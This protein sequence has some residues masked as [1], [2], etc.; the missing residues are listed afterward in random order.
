MPTKHC[1]SSQQTRKEAVIAAFFPDTSRIDVAQNDHGTLIYNSK[2]RQVPSM[3]ACGFQDELDLFSESESRN[4]YF[5]NTRHV[6]RV[7]LRSRAE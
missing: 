5:G 7:A 3:L 4:Q 6:S 1:I 2:R